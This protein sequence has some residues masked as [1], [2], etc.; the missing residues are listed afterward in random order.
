MS[1]VSGLENAIYHRMLLSELVGKKP[2][3]MQIKA[4]IDNRSCVEAIRS[5]SQVDD[6]RLRIEIGSVKEMLQTKVIDE[7]S[8]VE[9]AEQLADVLTKKGSSGLELQEVIQR[10]MLR[11]RY[12]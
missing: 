7:V 5:S 3:K 9:G 4:I 6:K 2:E 11:K 1:L 8:W 12:I 10:G